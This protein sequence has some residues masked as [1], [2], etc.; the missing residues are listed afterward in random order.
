[1]A[2]ENTNSLEKAS[3][4]LLRKAKKL[5]KAKRKAYNNIKNAKIAILIIKIYLFIIL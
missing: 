3:I 5:I 4:K 1:M 2:L